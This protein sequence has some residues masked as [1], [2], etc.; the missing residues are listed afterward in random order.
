MINSK[1]V[2]VI[3]KKPSVGMLYFESASNP[4]TKFADM[5]AIV[6]EVKKSNPDCLIVV[7]NTILSPIL[8]RP[9]E[10]GADI[11]IESATKYI[12]GKGDSLLGLVVFKKLAHFKYEWKEAISRVRQWR[13][14]G[15]ACPSPMTCWLACKGLETLQLRMDHVS[16]STQKI[17]EAL[18][19][20]NCISRV[21]YVGLPSHPTHE[22]AKR[23][24]PS[25]RFGGIFRFFFATA[26]YSLSTSLKEI[27]EGTEIACAV[28]FGDAHTLLPPPET[29]SIRCFSA[30]KCPDVNGLWYRMAVGLQEP[31]EIIKR[32][33]WALAQIPFL[34]TNLGLIKNTK[35]VKGSIILSISKKKS[36]T[37]EETVHSSF[38]PTVHLKPP[39]FCFPDGTVSSFV[40]LDFESV[41][42]SDSRSLKI[43]IP[44]DIPLSKIPIYCFTPS[45][46]LSLPR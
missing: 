41:I 34:R 31:E 36:K 9:L 33:T 1:I 18:S 30:D 14:V 44:S 4:N 5:E 6:K 16:R 17:V 2:V 40:L 39:L 20:I 19:Q 8:F 46:L 24:I 27:L 29:D 11:V 28:S 12:G 22:I 42:K 38:D 13:I 32:F 10:W 23:H 35:T 26:N 3:N 15:G 37:P 7:D 43:K 25:L 21:V 45:P